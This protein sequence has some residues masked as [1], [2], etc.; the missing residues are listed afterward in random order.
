LEQL[1]QRGALVNLQINGIPNRFHA[2][3]LLQVVL[4]VADTFL[5]DIRLEQ[6]ENKIIK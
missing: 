5:V 4:I 6:E 3:C 1:F 2:V